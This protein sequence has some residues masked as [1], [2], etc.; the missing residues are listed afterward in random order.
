MMVELD[1][2]EARLL[3]AVVLEKAQGHFSYANTSEVA[4]RLCKLAARFARPV[5]AHE[6][7]STVY[8][9]PRREPGIWQRGHESD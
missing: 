6:I 9:A 8:A 4:D 5:R 7:A 3:Y 1:D 2:D